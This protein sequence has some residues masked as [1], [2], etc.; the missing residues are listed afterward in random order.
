MLQFFNIR[1]GTMI[2]NQND[3]WNLWHFSGK[4]QIK[5]GIHRTN[6]FLIIV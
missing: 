1:K 2:K 4:H 3:E 6:Q 5:S